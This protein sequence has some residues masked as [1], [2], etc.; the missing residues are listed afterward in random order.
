MQAPIPEATPRS[1]ELPNAE[2]MRAVVGSPALTT[3]RRAIKAKD[4][5]RPPLTHLV[6][7][8][9]VSNG[10]SPSSGRS[11]REF[12][13]FPMAIYNIDPAEASSASRY[14]PYP[15]LEDLEGLTSPT[16]MAKTGCSERVRFDGQP[17]TLWPAKVVQKEQPHATLRFQKDRIENLRSL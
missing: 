3:H 17:I 10:L 4:L 11:Y 6:H 12:T 5:G 9:H 2:P 8:A 7:C 14:G 1:G 15:F 16:E 13:S